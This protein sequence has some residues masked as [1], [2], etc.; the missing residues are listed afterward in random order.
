MAKRTSAPCH[1]PSKRTFTT[2]AAA[3]RQAKI[4]RRH[5]LEVHAYRC[6]SCGLYHHTSGK[7]VRG[8]SEANRR[9]QR[10]NKARRQTSDRSK[11]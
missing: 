10:Y 3:R 7:N 1:T 9:A 5:G 4:A 8:Y 2:R 6:P 11:S